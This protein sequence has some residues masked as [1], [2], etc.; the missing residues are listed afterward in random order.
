MTP[1]R[2]D[3]VVIGGGVIG[4]SVAFHLLMEQP[5]VK[6]AIID[7]APLSDGSLGQASQAAAGMLAPFAEAH[8]PGPF[9]RLGVESLRYYPDFIE[10][11]RE[12][13]GAEGDSLLQITGPGMLRIACND[14]DAKR[15][16]ELYSWQR[17]MG[18]GV[19]WMTGDEARQME[20]SLAEN[21]AMAL[22]SP[23]ERQVDPRRLR[24]SLAAA[25]RR[26]GAVIHDS[27]RV[28]FLHHHGLHGGVTLHF[29]KS[30]AQPFG[31]DGLYA[32]AVVFAGGA[33]ASRYLS[34]PRPE[35]PVFP[36]KGQILALD[37][38]QR[39]VPPLQHT[40]YA[41]DIY[42]V[43]RPEGRIIVGATEEPEA[44]FDV[45]VQDDVIE[46]LRRRAV[47]LVPDLADAPL[48]G[49]AWAGLRPAT[50]DGLPILGREA[51]RN[52]YIATGHFRN[53]ILLAPITGLLMAETMLHPGSVDAKLEPF[54]PDRFLEAA[55]K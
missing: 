32:D 46:M 33:L 14:T 7:L 19:E 43:P 41:S 44:G 23:Q 35:L 20:P 36:V 11:V 51:D 21:I 37:P 9:L 6:V 27:L 3:T 12:V 18:F 40:L 45:Q 24:Y 17:E 2:V 31:D 50:P 22:Y 5:G 53:G 4:L 29:A 10:S 54:R 42:L 8:D 55:T 25:C 13:A 52:V 15:L 28:S 26:L 48:D 16:S 47:S 1:S 34:L 38:G 30:D 49:P 39:I